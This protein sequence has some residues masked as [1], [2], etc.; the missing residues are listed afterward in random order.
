MI[1]NKKMEYKDLVD[2]IEWNHDDEYEKRYERYHEEKIQ[3]Y[4]DFIFNAYL[5]FFLD[6]DVTITC[7]NDTEEYDDFINLNKQPIMDAFI[8][9][10][11]LGTYY[12]T[13]GFNNGKMKF[14]KLDPRFTR[15]VYLADVETNEVT[16]YAYFNKVTRRELVDNK[17]W[18]DIEYVHVYAKEGLYVFK[19]GASQQDNLG[20][21]KPIITKTKLVKKYPYLLSDN[22]ENTF[23]WDNIPVISADKCDFFDKIYPFMKE[24]LDIQTT[25]GKL[26]NDLPDSILVLKNYS[27]TD[28]AQARDDLKEYRM[29]KVEGDGD[30]KAVILP[31]EAA[32]YEAFITDI[33]KRFFKLIGMPDVDNFGN[34]SGISLKYIYKQLAIAANFLEQKLFDCIKDMLHAYQ[35]FYKNK[36]YEDVTIIFN[37]TIIESDQEK[38]E[39]INNSRGLIS[40]E[41]LIKIHPYYKPEF[42][43]EIE[44]NPDIYS[45]NMDSQN[46][47]GDKEEKLNE[48][49]KVARDSIENLQEGA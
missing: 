11:S 41:D 3:L 43:Y 40:D 31:T 42:G 20:K 45:P 6:E 25:A 14:K 19:I 37:T 9:Y 38:I 5:A 35:D 33:T 2:L 39:N 8:D 21:Q 18:T 29:A 32:P 48:Y 24:I 16:P 36:K 23:E 44:D 27:G 47:K 13:Y 15:V 34:A 46:S 4:S 28:L 10:L 22:K 1:I 26:Y 49:R 7:K 12:M 17:T 30:M